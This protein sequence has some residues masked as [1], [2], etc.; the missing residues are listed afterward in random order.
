[1]DL[2]KKKYS[3]IVARYNENINWLLPYKDISYIYNKGTS[4]IEFNQFNIISLPNYGRESHTYLYHII[5]NYENLTEYNIFFQGKIQ[6]HSILNLEDYFQEK[7]FI[8]FTKKEDIQKFKQPIAH[9]GKWKNELLQKNMIASPFILYNW[10]TELCGIQ[11][12][13]SIISIPVAWGAIFSAS[14]KTIHQKPK[15]F[16]EYLYR[17]VNYIQNPEEGHFFERAWYIFFRYPIIP[18]KYIYVIPLNKDYSSSLIKKIENIVYKIITKN[19]HENNIDQIHYWKPYQL[20]SIYHPEKINHI[21]SNKFIALQNIF[22]S[23]FH[24]ELELKESFSIK[25]NINDD[26]HYEFIFDI[27]KGFTIFMNYI[28]I[29]QKQFGYHSNKNYIKI[30]FTIKN[31][32]V[33]DKNVIILLDNQEVF[34]FTNKNIHFEQIFIRSS[35][36]YQLFKIKNNINDIETD[37][38]NKIINNE[39]NKEKN[40][41]KEDNNKDDAKLNEISEKYFMYDTQKQ[42]IDIY[43]KYNYLDN[44]VKNIEIQDYIEYLL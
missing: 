15:E 16:Y 28:M 38:N 36:S 42:E 35:M 8:A 1:M 7:D 44:Y 43:Y 13:E 21:S 11:L 19:S 26:I 6:D 34:S 2:I 29:F 4:N 33:Q 22:Q 5:Q 39:D 3:I 40:I 27:Q 18:K 24:L 25:L 32:Q 9:F 17:Y 12:E 31:V 37:N 20:Y 30:Q 14:R 23:V 10:L 41:N